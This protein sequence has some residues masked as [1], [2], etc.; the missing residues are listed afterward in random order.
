VDTFWQILGALG[1]LVW[2]LDLLETFFGIV[3]LLFNLLRRG[4]SGVMRML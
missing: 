1:L 4:V 2:V 3:T